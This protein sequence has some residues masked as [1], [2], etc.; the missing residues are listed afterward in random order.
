MVG[1]HALTVGAIGVL[2]LGMM[3][4]VALGHTGRALQVSAAV[5]IAFA[6]INGA[7]A[8]RTLIAAA[9]PG[10]YPQ[11][12][13]IAGALW[14]AAFAIFIAEYAGILVRARADGREG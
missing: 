1:L 11:T 8:A 4:R 6:L 13:L 9:L 7:A 2:T 5:A 10:W 3:A 12:I 14:L